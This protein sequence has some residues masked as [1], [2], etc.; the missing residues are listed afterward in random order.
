MPE[1][2]SPVLVITGASSGI[3]AA[4][5]RAAAQE[6]WRLV[7][8]AR[9]EDKIEALSG[10]LGGEDTAVAQR[11][12]V[13]EWDQ[14]QALVSAA[15]ERF[16]RLDAFF[17]N[18][19]FGASRGFLEESVEHWRSMVDTNVYGCAL[20]I[21]AALGHFREQNAGHMLLTGSVAGRKAM[22]GS[23]YS[24]TKW[25]VHAMGEGLRAEVHE[26]DIRTTIIA[27][28]KVDTPFFDDPVQD[29]LQP[30]DIS[31]AVMYALSQPPH[32]D[33]SEVLVRPVHQ[34]G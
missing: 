1:S 11:C 4:T 20:S 2:D 30:E 16:G 32:V 13:T 27:P 3:G 29:A 33:V 18:A 10:E 19:G 6:G 34:P 12:D 25:A 21:R 15:L 31:R 14:Q 7:L 5:A 24:A 9:S 26:S 23:L 17:A 28:G 8:A 22:P